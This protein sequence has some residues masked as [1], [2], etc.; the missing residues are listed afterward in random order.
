[1][2]GRDL[3]ERLA[4]QLLARDANHLARGLRAQGRGASAGDGSIL[5]GDCFTVT[6]K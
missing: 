5:E 3:L 1:M 2:A 6:V 4:V